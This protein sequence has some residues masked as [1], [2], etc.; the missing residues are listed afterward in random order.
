MSTTIAPDWQRRVID[1]ADDLATKI[2]AL[3]R[4]I[5]G[6][7]YLKVTPDEQALLR[8]QHDAMEQYRH[9]LDE[10]IRRFK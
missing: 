9:L 2:R 10:R 4:F 1:E 7:S 8:N 6:P 5:A 3:K